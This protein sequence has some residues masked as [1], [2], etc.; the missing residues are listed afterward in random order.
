MNEVVTMQ[1][2]QKRAFLQACENLSHLA[3]KLKETTKCYRLEVLSDVKLLEK[4]RTSVVML[5]FNTIVNILARCDAFIESIG[6]EQ[7]ADKELLERISYQRKTLNKT[8]L[9]HDKSVQTD[10]V[11]SENTQVND[12]VVETKLNIVEEHDENH[13]NIIS[14]T[15]KE[16]FSECESEETVLLERD[17]TCKF[18]KLF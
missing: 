18:L 14:I 11:N 17:V 16:E 8:I 4:R 7:F 6:R 1:L 3:D 12:N 10:S 13:Q 15:I 2:E 9:S 5:A